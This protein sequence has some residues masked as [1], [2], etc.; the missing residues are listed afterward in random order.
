MDSK[1]AKSVII[2]YSFVNGKA[3]SGMLKFTNGDIYEGGCVNG[4][5]HGRGNL[6]KVNG[7]II[8]GGFVNG[9]ATGVC[10]VNY[11]DSSSYERI[12]I[13]GSPYGM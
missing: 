2:K 6:K 11:P 3:V 5:M 1:Q 4:I 13:N 9:K 12:F 7:E 10:K 8:E